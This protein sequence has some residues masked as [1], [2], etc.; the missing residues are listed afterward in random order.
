MPN[1]IVHRRNGD[2]IFESS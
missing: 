1:H 2:D